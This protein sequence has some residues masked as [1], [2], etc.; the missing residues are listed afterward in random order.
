MKSRIVPIGD[1]DIVIPDRL[2]YCLPNR[3]SEDD[4]LD[5][6]GNLLKAS[7]FY[8]LKCQ[9]DPSNAG[10]LSVVGVKRRSEGF[11]DVPM[12]T[13]VLAE[14]G[15]SKGTHS[16][17]RKKHRGTQNTPTPNLSSTRHLRRNMPR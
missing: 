12:S 11:T 14:H 16:G 17:S 2:I 4:S 3:V 15:K 9:E 1:R 7:G 8:S 13:R 5:V 6:D 10:S